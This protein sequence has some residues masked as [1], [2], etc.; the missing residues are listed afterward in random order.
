MKNLLL[1]ITMLIFGQV[2][3]AQVVPNDTVPLGIVTVHK[4]PRIDM[5]GK[6]MAEYNAAITYNNNRTARGYRLMVLSTNDRDLAMR[7]RSALLQQYPDQGVYMSF[8][9]PYIKLKFGN[10][11]EK[12]EAERVK[13]Q[14]LSQRLVPGNIYLVPETIEVKPD[15]NAPNPEQ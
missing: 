6:K 9:S 8:Q 13:K 14:L 12:D 7:T 3:L 4:D 2:C 1:S 11:L 10:F 15:K 5:L